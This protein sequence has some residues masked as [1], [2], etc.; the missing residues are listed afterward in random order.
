[1]T[2]YPFPRRG[3]RSVLCIGIPGGMLKP[4][5]GFAFARIQRDS[6]AI[7]RSLLAYGHPFAVPTSAWGYRLY[8]SVMLGMM[9]RHGQHIGGLLAML[10]RLGSPTRIFRFLDECGAPV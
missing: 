6:A 7:V 2:D 10:F 4:T 1:M 8:E 3:G 9:G 5:T